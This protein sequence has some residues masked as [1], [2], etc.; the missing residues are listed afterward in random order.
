M[1]RH[2][3]PTVF[4]CV[5]SRNKRGHTASFSGPAYR[6]WSP[7]L[8]IVWVEALRVEGPLRQRKA[9]SRAERYRPGLPPRQLRLDGQRRRTR[10][11]Q[12]FI[13]QPNF[14]LLFSFP[15]ILLQSQQRK[16]SRLRFS[17]ALSL[18]INGGR[19]APHRASAQDLMA[20]WAMSAKS[21]SAGRPRSTI[22]ATT[23]VAR[24]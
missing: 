15:A 19:A 7:R 16:S 9:G 17:V 20:Y 10:S 24:I 8:P 4:R 22:R 13:D 2:P 21:D 5:A 23:I 14:S 11:K 1:T 3:V 12:V 18:G 6:R